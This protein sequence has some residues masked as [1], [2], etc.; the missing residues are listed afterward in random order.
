VSDDTYWKERVRDACRGKAC[1]SSVLVGL[2]KCGW[3]YES[4]R[5]C[6]KQATAIWSLTFT[7]TP[8]CRHHAQE[9]VRKRM[10]KL[11]VLN[12]KTGEL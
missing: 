7:R 12:G 9:V 8:V 11:S 2:A 4:G 6:G 10:G 3:R 1:D 5:K